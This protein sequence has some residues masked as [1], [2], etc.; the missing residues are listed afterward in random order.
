MVFRRAYLARVSYSEPHVC[1]VVLCIRLG[2]FVEKEVQQ[3][4]GHRFSDIRRSGDFYDT[5]LVDERMERELRK[6]CNPF[7]EAA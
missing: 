1:A 6:V 4:Y 2:E 3:Q 5:M 7:Y